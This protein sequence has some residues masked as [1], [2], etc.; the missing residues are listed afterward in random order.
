MVIFGILLISVPSVYAQTVDF[1]GFDFAVK[2]FFQDIGEWL[3]FDKDQKKQVILN[4]I[5]SAKIEEEKFTNNNLPVPTEITKRINQKTEDAQNI[6]E[7]EL[8]NTLLLVIRNTN[9]LGKLNDYVSQFQ[10]IKS[11]P[12]GSD[13][14]IQAQVLEANINRLTLAQQYCGFIDITVLLDADDSYKALS[15]NYCPNLQGIPV[16]EARAVLGG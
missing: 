3:T 13:K 10:M 1:N 11:M 16:Q 2:S 5:A 14:E 15:D 12:D 9:E 8:F 7:S 4:S 6:D